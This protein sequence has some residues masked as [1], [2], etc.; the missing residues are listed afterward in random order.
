M[1]AVGSVL[2]IWLARRQAI[3]RV[4]ISRIGAAVFLFAAGS[5]AVF[6]SFAVA[7]LVAPNQADLPPFSKTGITFYPKV[8]P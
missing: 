1:A 8:K 7:L 5:N 6:V 4:T 2:S 3:D